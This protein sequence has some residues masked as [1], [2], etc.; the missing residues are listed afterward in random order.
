MLKIQKK[1]T[2]LTIIGV[3]GLF[4]S[5]IGF[6][7]LDAF[8]MKIFRT[9]QD[10]IH[11]NEKVDLTGLREIRASGGYLPRFPTL[12]RK[13]QHIK[14]K[15]IIVNAESELTEY[16]KGLPIT[17]LGYKK[18]KPELKHY[19]RRLVF[20][21]T[22]KEC[23]ELIS[24]GNQE[25]SQYGFIHK[26]LVIGSR[27]P[28]P[29]QNID[30]IVTFFD[31]YAPN[32]WIHFHCTHGKGRTSMLLVMLDIMKNAPK[33]ALKDIIKR[34]HFLG[35]VDLADTVR[36]LKGGYTIEMLENRKKFIEDFY[37]FVCQRKAGGIARWSDWKRQ[38]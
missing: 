27:S 29:P 21:S 34:Q 6:V 1:K 2:I 10:E 33:V 31:D 24:S 3:I 37:T 9:M 4:I 7:F 8:D 14:E 38:Q 19:V 25:A 12:V 16:I 28:V 26:N 22:I 18:S 11:S 36:W 32:Y 15:K 23:P 20:T 35:S 13:L 30:N 5:F 17:L